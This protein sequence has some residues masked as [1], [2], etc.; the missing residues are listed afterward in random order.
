M[1]FCHIL[2]VATGWSSARKGKSAIYM[3]A[4]KP[5]ANSL[6][7]CRLLAFPELRIG[8]NQYHRRLVH[9]LLFG[10][11]PSGKVPRIEEGA[12]AEGMDVVNSDIRVVPLRK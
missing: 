12:K 11:V 3:L 2:R 9:F 1:R 4:A 6:H 10:R 8:S 7:H 5:F